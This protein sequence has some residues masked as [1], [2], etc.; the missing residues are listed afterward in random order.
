MYPYKNLAI[1]C[2]AAS[3]LSTKVDAQS[4]G[5]EQALSCYGTI[6]NASLL[7]ASMR[8]EGYGL[9]WDTV[10][11][12]DSLYWKMF[13]RVRSSCGASDADRENATERDWDYRWR[14]LNDAGEV[15]TMNEL[16]SESESCASEFDLSNM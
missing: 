3:L 6:A 12:L 5:C 14:R 7:S 11:Y 13:S 10:Q 1:L 16:I 15:K 4:D 8:D 2:L 9:D